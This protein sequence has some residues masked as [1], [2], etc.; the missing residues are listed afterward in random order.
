MAKKVSSRRDNGMGSIYQR[1]NGTWVGK[2][3]IGTTDEGKPKAKYLSGKTEAEVKRKIREYNRAGAPIDAKKISFETYLLDWLKTYKFGTLKRSSY[4]TIEC[5]AYNQVIPR[6]GMIQLASLR[7]EDIQNLLTDLKD[8]GYSYSTI[9][10]T[11][12]CIN[13]VLRYAFEKEH[14]PKNP[15]IHVNMPE[16]SLFEFEEIQIFSPKES[17]MI[18]EEATREYSTGAPVYIYGYAFILML[19]T[20]IR[21]GEAIGL[22]KTDWDREN[23]TLKIQRNIQSVRKRDANGNATKGMELISNT[24]KTYSGYR[25][26]PLNDVATMAMEKLCDAHPESKY[27]VCSSKGT[28][29]P[30]ERVGR[31]FY[32]LLD[33]A[34]LDRVGVH[35]LRHTFASLLFAKG[36][37]IKT[38]SKLLG[39]ASVQITLNIYIH[40]LEKIDHSAVAKLNDLAEIDKVG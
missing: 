19:H 34:G 5:T 25:I 28:R 16:Q 29:V 6:L 14:I 36:T 2:I 33:N 39:H 32:R 31:T 8:E 40:L 9:K 17:A 12:D 4:D 7:S 3:V 11:H 15:M 35:T 22:E 20:G 21:L 37:D 26:L 13:A 38:V 23:R 1:E 27:V 10:K 18:V 30:P 24:T